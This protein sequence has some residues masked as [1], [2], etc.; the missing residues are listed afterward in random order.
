M[1]DLDD[2]FAKKDRKKSKAV[3]KF[4]T[5]DELAKKLDDTKTKADVR[6]KKERPATE[7]D[8][9]GRGGV[10]SEIPHAGLIEIF[11]CHV[12]VWSSLTIH[13]FKFSLEMFIHFLFLH[14]DPLL[15]VVFGDRLARKER[16]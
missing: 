15:Y 1:A 9:A 12:V 5:T 2:F 14:C 7:G 8:E 3:K 6:P 10:S 13:F 11:A 4:A 16:F